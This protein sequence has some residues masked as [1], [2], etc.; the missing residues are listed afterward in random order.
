[1]DVINKL[2]D[3]LE[4]ENTGFVMYNNSE[5]ARIIKKMREW[6]ELHEAIFEHSKYKKFI[7]DDNQKIFDLNL[8][9]F[10]KLYKEVTE[11]G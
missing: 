3:R 10:N 8:E 11:S 2:I 7:Y 4:K 9:K 1:M 6:S 5:I